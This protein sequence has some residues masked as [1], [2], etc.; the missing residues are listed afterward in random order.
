MNGMQEGMDQMEGA[1]DQIQEDIEEED[2]GD[3]MDDDYNHQIEQNGVI[4]APAGEED[5]EDE[6]EAAAYAQM[7][8]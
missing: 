8:Q 7:A 2:S 5:D 1:P 3:D 6:E 4:E